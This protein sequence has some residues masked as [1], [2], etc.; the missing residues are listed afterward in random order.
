MPNGVLVVSNHA[1]PTRKAPVPAN[2][3]TLPRLSVG[4][5]ARAAAAATSAR[6]GRS[7][8]QGASRFH[9]LKAGSIVRNGLP[10]RPNGRRRNAAAAASA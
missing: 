10:G 1:V 3:R 7:Q 2:V 8:S 6:T 9:G 5:G 4:S